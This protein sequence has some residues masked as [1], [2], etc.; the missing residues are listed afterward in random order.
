MGKNILKRSLIVGIIMLFLSTACLPVLADDNIYVQQDK[1][2][3]KEHFKYLFRGFL[4]IKDFK[5]KNV[6]IKIIL[7]INRDGS[8]TSEEIQEI[9][10]SNNVNLD[11]YILAQI[12]T[13]GIY[14]NASDGSVGSVPWR[15]S[16]SLFNFHNA[17]G[18]FVDYTPECI[19]KLYGWTLQVD[20]NSLGENDG[21]ILGY[22]GFI[23]N[24]INSI[25]EAQYSTFKLDG[26]GVLIL[27]EKNI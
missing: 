2:L 19:D 27:H 25:P 9:I 15:H 22:T 14:Y 3:T 13:T 8:A 20:G 1:V 11:V 4:F 24:Y 5:I 6:I 23:N 26:F 21:Y 18:I 17:K 10:D 16:F 7:E 12:K